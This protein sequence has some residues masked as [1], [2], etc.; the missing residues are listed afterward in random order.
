[1]LNP[2]APEEHPERSSQP[3]DLRL[4]RRPSPSEPPAVKRLCDRVLERGESPFRHALHAAR[5]VGPLSEEHFTS[6]VR[7]FSDPS[8]LKQLA[9]A[10]ESIVAEGVD[11]HFALCM[12]TLAHVTRG[13]LTDSGE[14]P[15]GAKMASHRLTS[16]VL[17]IMN[18]RDDFHSAL[19]SGLDEAAAAD[20][21][22]AVN[23]GDPAD[24]AYWS[25]LELQTV[26]RPTIENLKRMFDAH[27]CVRDYLPERSLQSQTLLRVV[28]ALGERDFGP[29]FRLVLAEHESC[30][31]KPVK[32]PHDVD[33]LRHAVSGLAYAALP[34]IDELVGILSGAKGEEF[35]LAANVTIAIAKGLD[36]DAD[37]E[38]L[39]PLREAMLDVI[40]GLA[41]EDTHTPNLEGTIA[42]QALASLAANPD[43]VALVQ[44]YVDRALEA[45]PTE[46]LVDLLEELAEAYEDIFDTQALEPL[47]PT[48]P[49]EDP[50][51]RAGGA[52]E[53]CAQSSGGVFSL[54]GGALNTYLASMAAELADLPTPREVKRAAAD[55]AATVR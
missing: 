1:M 14:D 32:L 15:E 52:E 54:S 4:P 34:H 35:S 12:P 23:Q 25:C 16:L 37:E 21:A 33:M 40:D 26:S 22:H 55:I 41:E 46:A 38:A 42:H 50:Q 10:L 31:Q 48:P 24:T 20:L 39:R 8:S 53:R 18:V 28:R 51:K 11:K 3:Q 13:L 45:Q 36:H 7:S 19:I 5:E 29:V 6:L 17:A 9:G 30:A 44:S 2:D 47:L 49:L 43:D 27:A